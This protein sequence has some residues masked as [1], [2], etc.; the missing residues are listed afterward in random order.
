M[1][2]QVA[3]R[4]RRRWLKVLLI[5]AAVVVVL[6]LLAPTIAGWFAPG[7][8]GNAI[9]GGINGNAKVDRVRLSWFGGQRIGPVTIT[10]AA[11]KQV[12]SVNIT[13][14]RGLLGLARAGMSMGDLGEVRISGSANLTRGPD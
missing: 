14:S 7:L 12:A 8:V 1:A 10:D 4:P 3:P 13:A 9:T 2:D 6:L 5:A 11:G